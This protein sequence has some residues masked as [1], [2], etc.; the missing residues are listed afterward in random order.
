MELGLKAL[1]LDMQ[2]VF[3]EIAESPVI[4]SFKRSSRAKLLGYQEKISAGQLVADLLNQKRDGEK[5]KILQPL[6]EIA[7]DLK[8]NKIFGDDMILNAAFLVK[9]G[10]EKE[11]DKQVN[12]LGRQYGKT[13]KFIYVGPLSPFNFIKLE[14]SLK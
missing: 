9:K 4:K 10:K 1:W 8:E 2:S 6:K 12:M 14:L 3:Q 11:F 7:D 5:E 13:V